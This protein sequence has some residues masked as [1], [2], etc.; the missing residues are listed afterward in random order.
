MTEN[1]EPIGMIVARYL[2]WI[3]QSCDENNDWLSHA[4]DPHVQDLMHVLGVWF[5]QTIGC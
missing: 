5:A 1:N 4:Y 3:V 2:D